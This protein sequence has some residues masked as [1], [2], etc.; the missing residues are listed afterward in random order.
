MTLFGHLQE[1]TGKM[2]TQL[3]LPLVSA[4]IANDGSHVLLVS[5]ANK[6]LLQTGKTFPPTKL[7]EFMD[8]GSTLNSSNTKTPCAGGMIL[9]GTNDSEGCSFLLWDMSGEIR[10]ICAQNGYW[11]SASTILA[12]NELNS[13]APTEIAFISL[14]A[15]SSTTF[16]GVWS[17]WSEELMSECS[18]DATV[19]CIDSAIN[20]FRLDENL[21]KRILT[22]TLSSVWCPEL[23]KGIGA[24]DNKDCV[25]V[26]AHWT[27]GESMGGHLTCCTVV[28]GS[29]SCPYTLVQGFSSGK[30][31]FV[32]LA[33]Y[34]IPG[35]PEK[36]HAPDVST[37][38]H[39][40][41]GHRGLVD[42]FVEIVRETAA[43]AYNHDSGLIDSASISKTSA[44]GMLVSGGQDGSLMF[45][46]LQRGQVGKFLFSVHP[47]TGRFFPDQ[48][49]S[50]NEETARS[51]FF[52]C[53][54]RLRAASAPT[55]PWIGCTLV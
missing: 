35:A 2:A 16:C 6:C 44:T 47:H 34:A 20:T 12:S 36:S 17:T 11:S 33:A 46:S 26:E 5:Q 8:D 39:S 52:V 53:F 41:M 27:A 51:N 18:K 15:L 50:K 3:Q 45:W 30:I 37:V 22:R 31:V 43:E 32:S 49:P 55:S 42:C 24:G 29:V 21:P 14:L 4:S 25:D 23:S 7:Q 38:K 10:L 48:L 13:N 54:S 9:G 28:G 40:H 19:S 1:T